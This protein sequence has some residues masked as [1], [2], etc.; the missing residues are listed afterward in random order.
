MTNTTYSIFDEIIYQK[1]S[2]N[3][4]IFP[5][6]HFKIESFFLQFPILFD[7][8]AEN[9]AI[10]AREVSLLCGKKILFVSST[11]AVLLLYIM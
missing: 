5:F 2:T 6:R 11:K 10:A 9:N 3:A 4:M 1:T 8:Y 7:V